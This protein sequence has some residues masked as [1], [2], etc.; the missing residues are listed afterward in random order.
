MCILYFIAYEVLSD[1]NKRREYDQFGKS[2]FGDGKGGQGFS[3]KFNDFFKEF[4]KYSSFHFKTGNSRHHHNHGRDKMH[5]FFDD[6]FSDFNDGFEESDF[7]GGQ[8]GHFYDSFGSHDS[9]FASNHFET[10][11]NSGSQFYSSS[12]KFSFF[13][14]LVDYK[15]KSSIYI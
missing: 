12:S 2:A 9:Y 3:F 5:A 1:E 13:Y 15:A 11:M 10:D 8:F 7:G 6:L 4:D 14:F